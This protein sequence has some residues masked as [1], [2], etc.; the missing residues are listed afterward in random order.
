[1]DRKKVLI[2][3]GMS[4]DAIIFITDAPDK[5]IENWCYRYNQELENGENTYL[6]SLEKNYYIK[7]LHDSV[8]DD[9][10]NLDIIGYDEIYDLS[11]Y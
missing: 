9:A 4:D 1:M 6:D 11:D 5:E 2:K 3:C 10:E 8:D 7:V